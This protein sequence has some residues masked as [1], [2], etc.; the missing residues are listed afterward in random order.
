MNNKFQVI[1]DCLKNT[2]VWT[3]HKVGLRLLGSFGAFLVVYVVIAPLDSI[4]WLSF[5][6]LKLLGLV[7]LGRF[8]VELAKALKARKFNEQA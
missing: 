5:Q 4:V 7:F 2:T 3:F 8:L 6:V 1:L